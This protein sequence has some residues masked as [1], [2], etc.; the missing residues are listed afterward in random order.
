MIDDIAH[1]QQIAA[2]GLHPMDIDTEARRSAVL[3]IHD[4]VGDGERTAIRV[5]QC[6]DVVLCADQGDDACG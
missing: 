3:D 1:V 2:L 6:D 5:T 4:H